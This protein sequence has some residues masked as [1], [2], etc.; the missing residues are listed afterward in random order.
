MAASIRTMNFDHLAGQQVGTSVLLKVLGYGAMS[1]VFL[2]FQKS[3]KRQIAVKILPKSL[4]TSQMADFFQQ[5]AEA[6]AFLSHPCII[7]VYEIGQT[8]DFLFFTMQLVKG[9]S[10]FFFIRNARKNILPSRRMLPLNTSLKIIIKVLDALYYANNKGVVHRDI[11]PANILINKEQQRPIIT[12]FGVARSYG[13][14]ADQARVLVGTPTYMAPEQ[15]I[16]SVVDEQADVYATGVMLFEMLCGQ[17]PYPPFDSAKKLLKIKLRLRDRL[18]MA[19]PSQINSRIDK[20]LDKIVRKA[21]AF[22]K[23]IRFRTC[24]EFGK[25]IET[26]LKNR[27]YKG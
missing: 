25:A 11:K 8:D 19:S 24:G 12:D 1:V 23:N 4:L 9:N 5:E 27:S 3:L 16:S 18:F 14:Q 26:Y 2:A 6:A 10:L 22:D 17:L 15:I 13:G 20:T 7:P 21:V